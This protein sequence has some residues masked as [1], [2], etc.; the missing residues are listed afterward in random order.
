MQSCSIS[1]HSQTIRKTRHSRHWALYSSTI[2][3]QYYL[4]LAVLFKWYRS[5]ILYNNSNFFN[6]HLMFKNTTDLQ[7]NTLWEILGN[8][9]NMLFTTKIKYKVSLK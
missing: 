9:L 6:I 5:A 8:Y 7:P 2:C 4:A 1:V 3:M